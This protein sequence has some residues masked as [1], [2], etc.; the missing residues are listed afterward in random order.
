MQITV[1]ADETP[2]YDREQRIAE[3]I[4]PQIFDGEAVW[5]EANDR[6]FLGIYMPADEPKGTVIILH[7]RDVSPEDQNVAGPMRVGLA[8][9]GWS[10]LALQMPVLAKGKKYYDYIPILKFSHARIEAAIQ[11]VRSQSK[12]AVILAGH[13]CGAHMANHWLNAKGEKMIQ[14][15]IAMGLGT[16]DAGQDLKTPFPIGNMTVPVLDIYG[17]EEY[18]RPL[19]MV[20]ERRALLDQNA[21]SSSAQIEV[22]GAN[23]YFTDAGEQLTQQV[24]GWLDSAQF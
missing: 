6:E 5:L 8:E 12:E 18:P 15:Y 7:G 3:Q 21:N 2:D 14:G 16:T 20:P 10:T 19:A 22:E 9:S 11:F 1:F 4:E 13:S 23:H 24:L 17:S